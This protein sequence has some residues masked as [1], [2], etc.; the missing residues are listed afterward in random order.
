MFLLV[1]LCVYTGEHAAYY[2]S[3]GADNNKTVL[4]KMLII[5]MLIMMK[6]TVGN[7]C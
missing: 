3:A 2:I 7:V 1:C 5:T 4:V 6:M